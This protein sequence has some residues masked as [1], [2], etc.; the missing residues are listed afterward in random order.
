MID[1]K[2]SWFQH[3]CQYFSSSCEMKFYCRIS[4]FPCRGIRT[5][6][7]LL[8]FFHDVINIQS[9]VFICFVHVLPVVGSHFSS[10]NIFYSEQLPFLAS[11]T[12]LSEKRILSGNSVQRK[13]CLIAWGGILLSGS[14]I[15]F[16]TSMTGE[17]SFWGI[18]ITEDLCNESCSSKRFLG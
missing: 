9:F 14:W 12:S 6:I 8:P 15:L 1:N 13:W 4:Y 5:Q 11:Q 3:K 17:Q 16:L 10:N 7:F 18:Q 2:L